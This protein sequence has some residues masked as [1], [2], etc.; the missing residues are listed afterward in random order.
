MKFS[1]QYDSSKAVNLIDIMKW[2]L[3]K[4]R[5]FSKETSLLELQ[6]DSSLLKSK[7]DFIC[8]LGHASF[9]IQL[10]GVRI[11]LDPIF[12]DVPFYK[13]YTP[14]PYG[15]E[16]LGEIDY[17]FISHVHYDHF[18]KASIKALVPKKATFIA[19]LGMAKYLYEID[20][21][22][23]IETLDWYESYT[24]TDEVDL[25]LVPAKHWGRRGLF[26]TNKALWGGCLLNSSL[27]S[28]YFAGDTAYDKHFKEIAKRY[29]IE[30]ALL[31][32]GA[33]EPKAIMQHNH[34]NPQEALEAFRDLKAKTFM[35]M[36]YGTFQLSD[37]SI[38]APMKWLDDLQK[39][40]SD[41]IYKI[42]IG[43]VK[44]I[45]KHHLDRVER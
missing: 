25:T 13:R 32:I 3:T 17:I 24:L 28:I 20:K 1:N 39:S 36:H 19:P 22:V 12:G 21:T 30:Y 16:E 38:N 15:V 14:F 37:E 9:L 34:L 18:D 4:K 5:D 35:P 23:A 40:C 8:W 27:H 33:Y 31:P 29:S 7:K 11:L 44:V 2:Q 10:N 41:E 45:Y 42:K 43:E 6:D 26:D